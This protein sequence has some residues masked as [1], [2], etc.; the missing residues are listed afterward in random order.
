[1]KQTTVSPAVEKESRT[2]RSAT[3]VL[4]GTSKKGGLALILSP[5]Q[6]ML[7][8]MIQLQR[9]RLYYAAE[10][11]GIHLNTHENTNAAENESRIDHLTKELRWKPDF[12]QRIV[13]NALQKGYVLKT[14]RHLALT[15]AG[16]EF[17]EKEK[18][19][20]IMNG[21]P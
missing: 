7:A 14:N 17:A 12:A 10:T 5:T 2:I 4:T 1:M 13:Q 6:G 15:D 9:Q 19:Q 11:L 16:R 18:K 21:R 20:S 8:R 3:E